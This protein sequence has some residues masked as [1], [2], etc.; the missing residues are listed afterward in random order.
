LVNRP[1]VLNKEEQMPNSTATII[2]FLAVGA[3]SS[4]K[5]AR[6]FETPEVKTAA[7]AA[8]DHA[9]ASMDAGKTDDAL[10]ECSDAIR[11]DPS[12]APAYYWCARALF[13][14]RDFASASN[15]IKDA[16]DRDP[17]YS[18]A[19]RLKGS[20]A[21]SQGDVNEAIESYKSAI[22]ENPR[23]ADSFYNIGVVLASQKKYKEAIEE[24]DKAVSIQPADASFVSNRGWAKFLAGD[25]NGAVNDLKH[26]TEIAPD[27]L[28]AHMNLGYVRLSLKQYQ[29]AT[30]DFSRCITIDPK[31][32][33]AYHYRAL[34]EEALH[35][36]ADAEHD[37]QKALALG[38]KP[39]LDPLKPAIQVPI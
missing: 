25:K 27:Y 31:N 33:Y 37:H 8:C 5:D 32:P 2:I 17:H 23:D 19:Y 15:K 14:K 13:A 28:L 4:L 12:L 11:I 1:I 22:H 24:Y 36:K 26:A 21:L 3:I 7:Q 20:I 35:K 30:L 29:E 38:Y 9:K 16:L 34:A 6:A 39:E 10:T 18:D